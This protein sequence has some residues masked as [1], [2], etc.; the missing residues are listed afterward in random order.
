MKREESL[1][2]TFKKLKIKLDKRNKMCY[3]RQA[4]TLKKGVDKK[5]IKLNFGKRFKKIA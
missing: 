1:K 4:V 5:R 2:E 3:T